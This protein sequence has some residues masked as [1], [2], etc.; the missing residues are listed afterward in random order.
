M[1]GAITPCWQSLEIVICANIGLARG[2][3]LPACL[4]RGLLLLPS[5]AVIGMAINDLLRRPFDL[6][7][8]VLYTVHVPLALFLDGQTG[9]ETPST[10]V[11]C[12]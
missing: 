6:F 4:R 5:R 7:I 1:E 2:R 10:I 12:S 3:A 11:Y 8:C 9:D